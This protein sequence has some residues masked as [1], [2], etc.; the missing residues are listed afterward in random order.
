MPSVSLSIILPPGS[1]HRRFFDLNASIY[2]FTRRFL[3][4]NTT[5]FLWD[6]VCGMYQMFDTGILDIDSEEDYW[7]MEAIAHHLY[8][9]KPEFG[10]VREAIRR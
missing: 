5:G 6:G 10:K 2:V 3:T 8:A 9:A 1:K 7:L 4:E